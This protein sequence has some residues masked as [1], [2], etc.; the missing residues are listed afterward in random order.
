MFNRFLISLLILAPALLSAQ[1]TVP[2]AETWMGFKRVFITID[3]HKAY[4]VKPDNP[5]PGNPWV[6]RA[7]FPDWH[8]QIDSILLKR[9][10]Y[11]AYINVDDQYGSPQAMQV[12]DKFYAYL[13]GK[14][15]LAPRVS[16]EGVSRGALYTMAWAK[17]NPDKVNCIY[18]ETPVYDFKSWPGGKG[19]GPGDTAAWKQLKQVYNFTEQQAM[20]Y[21]DNPVDHLE[22][23]A[24]FK[25]P[26]LNV[27][28]I[29]DEL[30]PRAENTDLFVQRYT[31][32]GG[33]ANI[34]PVTDG[35]QEL[36]GH[37][38]PIKHALLYADFIYSNSYPVKKV[39]PY[40]DYFT[41]RDGLPHFFDAA[42][43]KKKAT[44]AFL[45][46]SI[47]YNPGWREKTCAYLKECFPATEF[48]FIAAGIPSLGSLPH[49]FRLQKDVLD[50]GKIDLLFV[51][52]AVNDRV[53]GTDSIT[54]V[55]D[56][57]GIIRHTKQN[58]PLVDIV[59]MEFADPD[60]NKDYSKGVS[61]VEIK[62][63]E[64]VAGHYNFP[65]INLAKEVYDKLEVNEFSWVDDF[66]DLHPAPFGQE[67]YF[68]T[69]KSLLQACCE[70]YALHTQPISP[71]LSLPK[72]LDKFSFTNGSYYPVTHAKWDSKWAYTQNW[73]PQDHLGTRE[74][75]VHVPVLSAEQPGASLTLSF[76]GTAVGIAIVSGADAG[77]VIYSID[78]GPSKT[79]DLYTEWSSFLH[80]PWYLLL[81]GSLANKGHIL[82]L[83]I[84]DSKNPSSKGNACRIVTFFKND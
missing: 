12:W 55:R 60:K 25:V 37:H 67:L 18:N 72:P 64:L 16:L 33:P 28:G 13:T 62:N 2:D 24:G 21:R 11:V 29:N 1:T 20:D 84:V 46:G 61:P 15:S 76:K 65:S 47:T 26:V 77:M 59:M 42:L 19:K 53:N 17:R 43:N 81:D 31:A 66:K 44:V 30:A 50:S 8:T 39:L 75:F 49:V 52:A 63:H 58:N 3:N 6:W 9:G 80:L 27:I 40:T 5:L 23:L 32:L 22:G 73:S 35:P 78:G 36:R 68:E 83:T 54:Q 56:L 69:I 4:Y 14:V 74:G 71:N 48:H 45:G 57:E 51:E 7:S 41:T 79:I 10:F 38:F 34:Y 82:K 70:N